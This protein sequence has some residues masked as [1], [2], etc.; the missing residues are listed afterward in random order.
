MINM[1]RLR[2]SVLTVA[3]FKPPCQCSFIGRCGSPSRP[4]FKR[5]KVKCW[6]EAQRDVQWHTDRCQKYYDNASLIS[7]FKGPVGYI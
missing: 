4:I 7:L 5:T 2:E 1:N 3:V 6:Q